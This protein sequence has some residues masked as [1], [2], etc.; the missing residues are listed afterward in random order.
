MTLFNETKA[1]IPRFAIILLF[2]EAT[3]SGCN[4][5]VRKNPVLYHLIFKTYETQFYL[6]ELLSLLFFYDHPF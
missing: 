6:F 2:I 1:I 3:F 5:F 4:F